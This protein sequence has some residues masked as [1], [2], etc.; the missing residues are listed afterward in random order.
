MYDVQLPTLN[1]RFPLKVTIFLSFPLLDQPKISSSP[2]KWVGVGGLNHE[3]YVFHTI[4]NIH[5]FYLNFC[6]TLP[7]S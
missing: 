6:E 5:W 1:F 7:T 2:L 3:M 4:D